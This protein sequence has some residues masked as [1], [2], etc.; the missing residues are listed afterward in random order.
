MSTHPTWK[1][2]TFTV[3]K[4]VFELRRLACMQVRKLVQQLLPGVSERELNY[5]WVMIDTDQDGRITQVGYGGTGS[6]G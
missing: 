2:H 1:C 4:N 3:T 5:L 6:P